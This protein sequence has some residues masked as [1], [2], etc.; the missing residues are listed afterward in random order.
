MA[1]PDG[2]RPRLASS[3]A[4]SW[5][6]PPGGANR[7]TARS[8][9]T[10][11]RLRLLCL[12]LHLGLVLAHVGLVVVALAGVE[13]TII[14]DIGLQS[15]A[16]VFVTAVATAIGTV[17]LSLVLYWTQ[18]LALRHNLHIKKTLTATHDNATAW[19]GI[20]SALVTLLDQIAV[21][22]S[23][24]GTLS[25][26]GYLATISAL[27]VTT[28]ALFSIQA[29][30]L[31]TPTP[32]D[33]QGFPQINVA[34]DSN[35]DGTS[36]FIALV[37]PFLPWIDQVPTLG[38][39]NG[40][41]YEVP[42][43]NNGKDSA[44]VNAIG[45]NISCGYLTGV[46]TNVTTSADND[47]QWE[48]DFGGEENSAFVY[49]TVPNA[50]ILAADDLWNNTVIL[51]STAN[52]LDSQG[53]SASPVKLNPPMSNV[54]EL[55]FFQCFKSNVAQTSDVDCRTR[56]SISVS[57]NIF[58]NSSVWNEQHVS[59]GP[60]L[61]FNASLVEIDWWMDILDNFVLDNPGLKSDIPFSPQD[62]SSATTTLSLAEVFLTERLGLKYGDLSATVPAASL[63]ALENSL[64][65]LV[66]AVYWIAG[67]IH[68]G[69]LDSSFEAPLEKVTGEDSG[70]FQT[71]TAPIFTAGRTT[72]V[73]PTPAARLTISIYAVSFGLFASI[74]LFLLVAPQLL[75]SPGGKSPVEGTGLLHIMWFLRNHPELEERV[76]QVDCPT[77]HNLRAA[78]MVRVALTEVD[79][80]EKG[81]EYSQE[82]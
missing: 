27:H 60:P 25:V 49:D 21:T 80:G 77:D 32:I 69:A 6:S 8:M 5:T 46:N 7:R 20:G 18:R 34:V 12:F 56:E 4:S 38:L 2:G 43:V 1:L 62:L 66:A 63:Q 61:S 58:K 35:G 9:G 13:R 17:Y 82:F 59:D 3:Q 50:I 65:S 79:A 74:V 40:S 37:L 29:F 39:V 51:Y 30:N 76:P 71:P 53:N 73:V 45:F 52:I 72:V 26:F 67:N 70:F 55:Y 75:Q 22:S 28:P 64:S 57:P 14:F 10:G 19:S 54:T 24:L 47:T 15:R 36:T 41:I 31:S 33:T 42:I 11:I 48:I 16:S 23:V 44:T 68:A 81:R 78:G